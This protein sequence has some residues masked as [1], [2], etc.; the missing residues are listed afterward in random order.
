MGTQK[1]PTQPTCRVTHVRSPRDGHHLQ[2]KGRGQ[3]RAFPPGPQRNPPRGHA[4]SHRHV[5]CGA[6]SK[7]V[8]AASATR[9][10]DLLTAAPSAHTPTGFPAPHRLSETERC[11]PW[12][13]FP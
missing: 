2:A 4:G 5:P 13:T 6:V 11:L 12:Q 9:R 3:D 8:S 7:S 10:M 1:Q